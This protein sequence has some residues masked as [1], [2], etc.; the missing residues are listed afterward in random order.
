MACNLADDAAFAM[1]DVGTGRTS[2]DEGV[3]ELTKKALIGGI[4]AGLS[5]I[6]SLVHFEDGIAG[7]MGET[8]WTGQNAL[9]RNLSAGLLN[10]FTYAAG[11]GWSF[12]A[13]LFSESITGKYA[14]AGYAGSMA[15]R[16]IADSLALFDSRESRMQGF[17]AEEKRSVL[18]FNDF[19]GGIAES[20]LQ[21]HIAEEASL[22]VLNFRDIARIF[23]LNWFRNDDQSWKSTGLLQLRFGA[24][25]IALGFGMGGIDVSPR[26]VFVCR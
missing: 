6:D 25:D 20:A 11:G 17:G 9:M 4:T 5:G 8:I 14:L 26:S 21:F 24:D 2:W 10:S 18:T 3:V 7:L 1:F 16:F 19:I 22:N 15:H 12:N 23:D 13:D